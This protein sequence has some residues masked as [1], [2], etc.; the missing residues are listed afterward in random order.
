[1]LVFVEIG[2]ITTFGYRLECV[3]GFVLNRRKGVGC[4]SQVGPC[5]EAGQQK[6]KPV[7]LILV[8]RTPSVANTGEKF[9]VVEL[10]KRKSIRSQSLIA[11]ANRTPFITLGEAA[12]PS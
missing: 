11:S 6:L 2:F 8:K 5:F 12:L 9:A 1:M 4:L 3:S 7:H 10:H